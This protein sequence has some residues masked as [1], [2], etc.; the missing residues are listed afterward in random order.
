MN[1]LFITRKFPPAKGGMEKVAYDL[2]LHLSHLTTIELVKCNKLNKLLPLLYSCFFLKSYWIIFS[3][4]IDSIY[5]QDG[6]IAPL[7]LMLKFS[8]K[9]VV[10]TIHGLDITYKNIFYQFI[11]PRCVRRLDKII[12]I[13]QATKQACITRGIPEEKIVILPNGISD[14]LF[15]DE[16]KNIL[17]SRLENEYN[18]TIE[19]K[20]VLLSVG[21]L[22]ERKGFHW[23]IENVIPELLEQRNDF[24]YFIAGQGPF[25]KKI[26]DII[27]HDNLEDHVVLLGSIHDEMLKLLYNITDIFIMPN[28]PVQGDMEGFGI[29][30]IEASSCGIPV[31]ASEIEGITDTIIHEENGFLIPSRN[32]EAFTGTI[33]SIMNDMKIHDFRKNARELTLELFLWDKIADKYL[34]VLTFEKETGDNCIHRVR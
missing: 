3:K 10:I 20:K 28:I 21:R 15:I 2:Y 27:L 16:D 31:V 32:K 6:L 9:P 23:F 1:V 12:C 17:R 5:L 11:I 22:V 14:E 18:L 30:S 13:S 8:G 24:I 19:N 29:V 7:G 26:E 33:L 34:G 4:K 25:K